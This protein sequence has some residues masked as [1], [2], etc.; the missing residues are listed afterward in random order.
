MLKQHVAEWLDECP[1][2]WDDNDV[3]DGALWLI[4]YN[5]IEP[6]EEE[7]EEDVSYIHRGQS[8]DTSTTRI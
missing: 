4:V 8:H 7:E 6:E 1:V 3:I 5:A 2:K